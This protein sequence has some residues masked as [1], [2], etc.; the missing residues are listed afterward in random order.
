MIGRACVAAALA[1]GALRACA[2]SASDAYLTLAAPVAKAG[3]TVVEAQWDIALRDLHFVLRLDDDGDG[4]LT[5]GEVRRHRDEIARYAVD[6]LRV[7]AAGKAC[8]VEPT[9]QAIADRVDGAYAAL[10]VR[11]TCEG[12]PRAV[13]VDY[14]LF[15]DVDPSH[16]GILVM[17]SGGGA[18]ALLS[19]SSPRARLPLP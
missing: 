10:F 18:T 17:K 3:V 2:H 7:E 9:R 12:A 19:P 6:R 4:A 5:W 1:L 8:R 11:I 16:R 15:F 13:T 14:K